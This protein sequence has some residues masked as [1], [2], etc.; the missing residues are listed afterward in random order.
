VTNEQLV[1]LLENLRT[2]LIHTIEATEKLIPL[3]TE[4]ELEWW[5]KSSDER[6]ENQQSRRQR[7]W[8]PHPD[9]KQKY[10]KRP[11]GTFVALKPLWELNR[12]M[13]HMVGRLQR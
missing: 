8:E 4:R 1:V 2:Q 9:D 10:E 3:G 5:Y 12:R 13:V 6:L 11:T 7:C